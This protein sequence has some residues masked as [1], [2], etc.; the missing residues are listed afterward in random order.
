MKRIFFI[1]VCFFGSLVNAQTGKKLG[2][3]TSLDANLA[4]DLA[5]VIQPEPQ[6]PYEKENADPGRFTYGASALVGYQPLNWFSVAGGLRYS[7]V[8][9]NFHLIYYK[10]QTNFYVANK[11]EE[12]L[13]YIFANFGKKINRTA[14]ESAGFLGLGVGKTEPLGNRFG[15]QFQL[16][17]DLQSTGDDTVVFVGLSYGIILFSN[18]KF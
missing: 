8:L 17:L 3:Y 14:A 4:I 10:F 15:H 6:T 12:D 5:G 18:K 2:F 13:T 16:G 7:Y 11:Y 9:P 1:L